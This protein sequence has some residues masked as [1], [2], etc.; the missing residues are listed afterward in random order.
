M[1]QIGF[2]GK[3][4]FELENLKF[5][6]LHF[7]RH[8]LCKKKKKNIKCAR[9]RTLDNYRRATRRS[10]RLTLK[11]TR[12]HARTLERLTIRLIRLIGEAGNKV[13]V[14]SGS[15]TGSHL[16]PGAVGAAP[17]LVPPRRQCEMSPVPP[18]HVPDTHG[19]T[20]TPAAPCPPDP[21]PHAS[22]LAASGSGAAA[23]TF[24]LGVLWC[25]H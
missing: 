20:F 3:I 7:H 25:S 11:D 18:A 14:A 10:C 17:R 16:L 2:N 15:D 19:S 12:A 1:N 24:L 9:R 6:Y 8:H 23:L 13:T 22:H 5:F 4:E 21:P